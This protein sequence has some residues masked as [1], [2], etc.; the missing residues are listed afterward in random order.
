MKMRN[1]YRHQLEEGWCLDVAL[2]SA[3]A[4]EVQKV[5]V[6]AAV[7]HLKRRKRKILK[8]TSSQ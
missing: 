8:K 7:V 6:R 4:Q 3:E 1:I 2:N 5:E